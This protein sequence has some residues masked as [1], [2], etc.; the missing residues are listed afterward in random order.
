MHMQD[1]CGDIILNTHIR[2]YDGSRRG[3]RELQNHV[4]KLISTRFIVFFFVADIERNMIW[5]IVNYSK[6]R[7][8]FWMKKNKRWEI[9]IKPIAMST[10][11]SLMSECYQLVRKL[12]ETKL[13]VRR[14][15]YCDSMRKYIRWLGGNLWAHN[16]NLLLSFWRWSLMEMSPAIALIPYKGEVL[17]APRIHIAALLCIFSRAFKWYTIKA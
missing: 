5:E 15:I 16:C 4:V 12:R 14:V 10:K 3:W 13:W 1:R 17:K 6:S 2:Y 7:R 8:K 11:W 9:F